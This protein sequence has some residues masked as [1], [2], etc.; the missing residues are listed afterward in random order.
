MQH[1]RIDGERVYLRSIT[2]DDTDMIV[3]WRNKESVKKYFFYRG[4]FTAESHTKWL[5]ERVET[6]E[7]IQFVVC[8][9]ESD[10]PI[11]C[12]YIR[13]IDYGNRKAEYGVFLGEDDVRGNGI[14]KEILNLTVD[15][16]FNELKLHRIYARV[17]PDNE[18]SLFSFLH[19]GFE[20]EAL[21]REAVLCDGEYV[22]VVILGRLNPND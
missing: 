5:K 17:R 3:R 19:C 21:L 13:D 4:E 14:G 18:P 20:K 11:G 7:V 1:I 12:T 22:D 2:Y 8:E 15:Y 10:R 16:A 9:H 6:G